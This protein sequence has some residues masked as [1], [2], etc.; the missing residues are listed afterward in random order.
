MEHANNTKDVFKII[1][2]QGNET[3]VKT[4]DEISTEKSTVFISSTV[5]CPL[6]CKF[7]HLTLKNYKYKRLT[8]RQIID[9]TIETV[10]WAADVNPT[11]KAKNLKLSW[12]GMGDAFFNLEHVLKCNTSILEGIEQ[13]LDKV[14]IST[15]LPKSVTRETFELV[16]AI[17]NQYPNKVRWF[18]SLFSANKAV[19]NYM[20]PN[21]HDIHKAIELFR[22]SGVKVI[23][24]QIFLE[25][26]ND[27]ELEV[28]ALTEFV[29]DNK[30]VIS[31]LRVLRY[32]ECENSWWYESERFDQI[33]RYLDSYLQVELKTQ[34]SPGKEI[35]AACGMFE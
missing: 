16:E 31:Q 26:V 22:E 5:G 14:D 29:N 10:K 1:H 21:T 12:M 13:P 32:N 30:D 33:I 25:G 17:N 20:L 18:Y 6:K 9:N 15:A 7:C 24:H 23:A 3:C 2:A 8:Q 35:K 28:Q 19:R 4:V 34:V 27:S 11:I